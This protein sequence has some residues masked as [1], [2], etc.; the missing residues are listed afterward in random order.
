MS[1]SIGIVG[2]P[3]AGKSTLFNGLVGSYQAKVADYPFTTIAPNVGT[4]VVKDERLERIAEIEHLGKAKPSTIKFIDVAGLVKGAHK[5]E[6]MG[7]EFLSH[8]RGVSVVLVLLNAFSEKANPKEDL[9]TLETELKMADEGKTENLISPKPKI[10]VLNVKETDLARHRKT[11]L[12]QAL[13][14][15]LDPII[16]SAKTEM[17]LGEL[18]EKERQDYMKVLE[19]EKPGL[20]K[21]IEA[22][23]KAL[24]LI[25]FFTL[26]KTPPSFAQAWPVKKGTTA[27]EAAGLIHSD[28]AKNFIKAEVVDFKNVIVQKGFE[29]AQKAGKMRFEGKDYKI[30]DSDVIHLVS[31]S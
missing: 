4:V 7:N 18:E 26:K 8:I 27:L 12:A 29:A 6:G 28:F 31:K 9:E 22:G 23:F 10:Y 5:G 24:D 14:A 20:E 17:E 19:I 25:S 16:L 13:R 2:L 30:Q 11:E 3:N 21:V 15:G 1:L